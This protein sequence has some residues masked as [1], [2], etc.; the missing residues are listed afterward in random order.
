MELTAGFRIY[1]KIDRAA[2]E[3]VELFRDLAVCDVD[4]IMHK[5]A[6][7]NSAIK[8]MNKC[9]LLGT[10]VTVKAPM[11][12]NLMFHQA[13]SMAKE[14]D[15]IVVDGNGCTERA[16][17]GENMMQI[18]RQK[19]IRGFL[20]DG[21][22][23]D[24]Q[25]ADDLTDFAVFARGAMANAS[26]KGLGPGEINVPV[27]IGGMVVFP[28]D[29]IL[30]DRDG[31]IAIRP[32]DAEAV[33]EAAARLRDTQAANLALILKGES[34]RRWVMKALEEKGCVFIEKKWDEE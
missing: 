7:A 2:P 32:K 5:I 22:I 16:I 25:A 14:G 24:S 18:A 10:A 19:G 12:D 21:T 15:V 3:V 34:D 6:G 28:G 20:I 13:I 29:I 27:A 33:A 17:C 30:G 8:P 23:R 4:D 11:G 1:T 9:K 31:A 26:F